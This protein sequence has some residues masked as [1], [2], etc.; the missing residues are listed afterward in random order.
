MRNTQT[1]THT[2][3]LYRSFVLYRI[4]P[5]SSA[6]YE[7]KGL[8]THLEISMPI[9]PFI[10]FL[11]VQ[12][13]DIYTCACI[14]DLCLI[15]GTTW[16][17]VYKKVGI[18]A[19]AAA[20][21]NRISLKFY[22]FLMIFWCFIMHLVWIYPLTDDIFVAGRACTSITFSRYCGSLRT[23]MALVFNFTTD[24]IHFGIWTL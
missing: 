13:S 2:H 3:L 1:H 6:V 10:L 18:C 7:C 19:Y 4:C 22:S 15:T 9:K 8:G 21:R 23:C 16:T 5:Y 24:I 14:Y 20:K 12:H 17:F 11:H